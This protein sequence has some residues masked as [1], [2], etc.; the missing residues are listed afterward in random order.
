MTQNA[1]PAILLN[2]AAAAAENAHCP[3][4]DYPVGAA[5]LTDDGEIFCGCNVENASLGLTI[6]AERVAL[7]CAVAAGHSEFSALAVVADGAEIPFPC[8]ACRQV[9]SEFCEPAFPVYAATLTRLDQFEGVRLGD[10]LP[11]SFRM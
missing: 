3:Y 6:C 11:K 4:S 9:L 8:G 1:D 5:L 10:L 2:R 7:G